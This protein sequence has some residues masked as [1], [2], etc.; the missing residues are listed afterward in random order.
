MLEKFKSVLGEGPKLGNLRLSNH[1][2]DHL[3]EE[4]LVLVG[5]LS[6]TVDIIGN[7]KIKVG[8]QNKNFG[9]N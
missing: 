6:R 3:R 2:R 7:Q 8:N 4:D 5:E 1:Q 9:L